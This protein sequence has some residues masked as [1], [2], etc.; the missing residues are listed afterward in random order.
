MLGTLLVGGTLIPLS[1]STF[2]CGSS[3]MAILFDR[4]GGL[5]GWSLAVAG[6]GNLFLLCSMLSGL[7]YAIYG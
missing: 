3:R 4:R 1:V 6:M 5:A 2:V 7:E